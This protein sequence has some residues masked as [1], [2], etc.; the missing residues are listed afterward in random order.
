M[1]SQAHFSLEIKAVDTSERLIEG[2][3]AVT[4]N[5]DQGSDIIEPGAIRMKGDP[6]VFVGHNL[7]GLPVGL[8]VEAR[9]DG[10]GLFTRTKVHQTNVG[11]DLLAVAKERL[12]AGKPL[13]MSI[14]YF[15]KEWSW[16]N[17]DGKRVRVL[18]ELDLFE[19]SYTSIPMNRAAMTTAVKE[20]EEEDNGL[21]GDAKATY[22]QVMAVI[23]DLQTVAARLVS[24]QKAMDE[25]GI[26]DKA[27]R[28]LSAANLKRLHE[29]LAQV[30]NIHA[31]ACDGSNCPMNGKQHPPSPTMNARAQMEAFLATIELPPA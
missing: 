5:V 13:G 23:A 18:K 19:Y 25:L 20:G 21:E 9:E 16:E 17:R 15:P 1:T 8:S 11:D 28:R 27:G 29:A 6:L 24:D 30:Q 7:S 3:A 31:A 12:A 10:H 26:E 14:G 4:G 22:E 2:Y